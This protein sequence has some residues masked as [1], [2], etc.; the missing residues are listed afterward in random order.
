MY[1]TICAEEVD[2]L[3]QKVNKAMGEG[4]E[5]RGDVFITGCRKC[6]TMVKFEPVDESTTETD[7][8]L[9]G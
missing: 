5:L 4:W 9:L 2:V 1:R 6:Q 7:K 8:L 3:D